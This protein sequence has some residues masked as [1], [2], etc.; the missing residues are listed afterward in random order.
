MAKN[1]RTEEQKPRE[2]E[3]HNENDGS[4]RESEEI[5]RIIFENSSTAIAIMEADTTISMVNNAYCELS[6]YS[7]EE[8]IGTSWT[9]LVFPDDLER[10][11]EYNRRR[12]INPADAP[13]KYEFRFMAR[14]GA[15]RHGLLSVSLIGS[16]KKIITSYLDITEQ[17]RAEEA[18]LHSEALLDTLIQTIPDLIWLK[19][20]DGVFLSC[21]T[22]FERF[23]GAKKSEIIGKTD[24]DFIDRELADSFREYDRLAMAKGAPSNNEEWVTFN[25]DGHRALLDTIKTPMYNSEGKLIGILGIARDI[26]E[27]ELS[28]QTL[29]DRDARFRMEL[30]MEL[31]ERRKSQ[32]KLETSNILLTAIL[33]SSPNVIVFALDKNYRY[34]TFNKKHK[35]IMQLIWGKEITP[36]MS[37]LEIISNLADKEKARINFNRAFAGESFDLIEEYGD[38]ALTRQYWQ[39]FYSPIRS[40][41]GEIIGITCYVLDISEQKRIE[42]A[43]KQSELKYRTIVN[44]TSE[45]IF[46]FDPQTG[47]IIDCNQAASNMYG[48]TKEEFLRA[49]ISD[50]GASNEDYIR[51]K[52]LERIKAAIRSEDI[53]YEWKGKRKNNEIFWSEVSLNESVIGGEER[54]IAVIRDVEERKKMETEILQ[55]EAEL[56][57]LNA[58]K[59]KFFSIIS[60]DLRSPFASIIGLAELMDDNFADL[61]TD[62][63]HE[64]AR[65]INKTAQSTYR[66][67]ENLLEWSRLQ[68]GVIPFNPQ[69]INLKEEFGTFDDSMVEIA[70]KKS[71][72]LDVDIPEGLQVTADRN[73]LHSILRNLVTNAI[74]FT[75]QNGSVNVCAR[76]KDGNIV[77]FTIKDTGIGMDSERIS[78]LFRIDTNVSRPGTDGEASSGLGLILCKEFVEKQGGTIWVESGEGMG[79]IFYFTIPQG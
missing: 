52:I 23:F 62:K 66:L 30:E 19:N 48:L 77:L 6:G 18:L 10:I 64:Y 32:M 15:I 75:R 27:R 33:E 71:I 59:D 35:E 41:D 68:Q 26:T 4:Q 36:G 28:R 39:N 74:K 44:S 51:G 56:N 17:K 8:I 76:S 47:S 37:M 58:A 3:P 5:F 34:L 31:A 46:I 12:F 11:K 24:Y 21:N 9:K 65:S 53:T 63:L 61:S 45:A 7:K 20:T 29:A 14:D 73:M 78:K 1:K 43:L 50:I 40:V 13:N 55:R 42:E 70:R 67:L 2:T 38:E 69:P 54:I 60:H 57:E 72:T 22:M 16:G 49:K 25:D 79:S